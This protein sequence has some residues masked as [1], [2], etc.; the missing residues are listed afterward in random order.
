MRPSS[1]SFYSRSNQSGQQIRSRDRKIV[2]GA[3]G[4]VDEQPCFS[5]LSLTAGTSCFD[6]CVREKGLCSL[7]FEARATVYLRAR[8]IVMV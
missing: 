2:N 8:M 1:R 6:V 7:M 5:G 4:A 3:R